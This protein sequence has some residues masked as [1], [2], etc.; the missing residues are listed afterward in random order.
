[1]RVYPVRHFVLKKE[2]EKENNRM[3]LRLFVATDDIENPPIP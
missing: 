1:M 3:S 2:S